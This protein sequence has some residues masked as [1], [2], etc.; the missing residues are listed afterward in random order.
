G[1][2]AALGLL[3]GGDDVGIGGA[4]AQVAA[5][6]LADF[7]G[8]AVARVRVGEQRGGRHNLARR[9]VAALK[10][11]VLDKRGLHGV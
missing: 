6:G 1:R 11:V 3:D 10:S 4:A 5:H 8:R 9:A 7:D 2:L